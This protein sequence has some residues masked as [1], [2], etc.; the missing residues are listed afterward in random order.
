MP[1]KTV[2]SP[3]TATNTPDRILQA[4]EQLFS[5]DGRADPRLVS[6]A[7]RR[8]RAGTLNSC[9]VSAMT[10]KKILLLSLGGTI[11]MTG[12]SGPGIQP[13]LN[14]D[15]LVRA[16]PGLERVAVLETLSPMRIPGPSLGIDDVIGVARLL[17]A[18]LAGDVDG[19]VVIQGTDTIEETAFLLD[20]LVPGDKP[21]VVTG[22]MRGPEAAGA[23][24][25][26]NVLAA[27]TVAASDEARGQ[28]VV[29]VL[30]D[31]IHAARFVQK[32]HTAWPSTF[33]S[34]AS[35]PIGAVIE[36]RAWVALQ[37]RRHAPIALPGL[38]TGEPAVPLP[39]LAN[40]E[41]PAVALIRL[42]LGDDGRLLRVLPELGYRGAVIEA[43]G[44]GHAPAS[45]APLLDDLVHAMPVVLGTRVAAGAVFRSTYGFPGSEIDLLARGAIHGGSLGGLKSRLLLTL[46][47]RTG[48]T[49]A[50][51]ECE[52]L[53]RAG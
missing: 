35:G 11:T 10:L 2:E 44:A 34:P 30:N 26:A 12:G 38:V 14:A 43:M 42:S 53:A 9:A 31:Q 50:E 17:T 4:A 19:T 36:G 24:G 21:V 22:A 33:M 37:P 47:L 40:G 28:G 48:L 20:L 8:H 41:Q 32:T 16:V 5:E 7:D 39:G 1:S 27:V 18:R 51:L 45:V 6:F 13:T 15:D 25:P 52:F 3:D 46:L 49:R 29:V 23:D